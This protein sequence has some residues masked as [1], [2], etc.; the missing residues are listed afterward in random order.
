[1][2]E[3]KKA[4][5]AMLAGNEKLHVNNKMESENRSVWIVDGLKKEL[6]SYDLAQVVNL[7]EYFYFSFWEFT[8]VWLVCFYG[9]FQELS[10]CYWSLLLA[11]S[12]SIIT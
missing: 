9:K 12:I 10:H 2:Y 3:K 4:L 7:F 5:F 6:D 11:G 1:M 8:H